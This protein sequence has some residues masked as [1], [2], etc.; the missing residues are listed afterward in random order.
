MTSLFG[1]GFSIINDLVNKKT[2]YFEVIFETLLMLRV[3]RKSK[4]N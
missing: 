3:D 4:G 2:G 1:V